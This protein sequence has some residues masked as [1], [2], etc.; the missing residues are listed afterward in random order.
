MP[1]NLHHIQIKIESYGAVEKLLAHDIIMD[2]QNH[3][4]V[5]DVVDQLKALHPNASDI[6][7][8]CACAIEDNII[9]RQEYLENDC[10][11]VLLSPVAGG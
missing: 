9:S 6:L 10:V 1:E 7:D 8:R 4:L 11:L 5:K 2:M 3:V